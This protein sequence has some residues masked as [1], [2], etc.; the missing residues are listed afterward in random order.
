MRRPFLAVLLIL[1]GIGLA[2][3]GMAAAVNPVWTAVSAKSTGQS[4]LKLMPDKFGQFN[5]DEP[6][7]KTMLVQA[8]A[9]N[10]GGGSSALAQMSTVVQVPLPSGEL[11]ELA[12]AENAT[13]APELAA[14]FP[15]IKT[16]TA[17]ASDL[18]AVS[19]T[20]DFTE[21]GF[22][23]M[24]YTAQGTVLIDP[25]VD[26]NGARTYISYYKTDYHPAD[27]APMTC[28]V[29]GNN[30]LHADH[31]APLAVSSAADGA[32][33]SGA[34]L[35]TYRLALA[36]TG[37]YSTFHGGT[38]PLAL[39]AMV[40]SINRVNQIYERDLAVRLQLVANNNLLVY[41]NAA[42]DPYSNFDGFSMLGENQTNV[43]NVIGPANYDIGHV[44]ST[45]GGG[46]AGLGVV[47]GSGKGE[48]VTGSP[49]PTGDPFDIDYVAHEIGHQF[50]GDHSFNGTTGS[51]SGNRNASTAWE[52]GSGTTIMAYAGICGGENLQLNSDSL[53][54]AGSIQEMITFISAAP[55]GASC[56]SRTALS[57]VA[58]VA[59]AG[60]DYTIPANTPFVLTGSG[61]DANGSDTLSYTWE[62]MSLGT[63]STAGDMGDVG[64]RP[65]FRSFN[66]DAS[67][68]RTFPKLESLRN[69]TT[70]IGERLPTTT[71]QLNFRLTVRDQHGGV[72]DDDVVL[73]V[74]ADAGPF[75]VTAPNG[76]ESLSSSTT[77]TWNVANTNLAPVS[78]A[79]VNI[80]LSTDG[81]TTFPVSLLSNAPNNGSATVNF[82]VGTSNTARLKVQCA[83]NIFFDISNNNFT[84]NSV[85][86]PPTYTLTVNSAGASGVAIGAVP[87]TYAGTTNYSKTGIAA[88]TVISLSAPATSGDGSFSSWSGCDSS[89]GASCSVTMNAARTVTAIYNYVAPA[90][91]LIQNPGFES[92]ATSWTQYAFNGAT[93]IGTSGGVPAH[94]GSKFAHLGG[95][96]S[97]NDYVEQTIAIPANVL[98]AKIEFWYWILSQEANPGAANDLLKVELYSTGGTKLATLT[99][100]SNLNA[101]AGWLKSTALDVSA[102]K[103]QTVR[104][105]FSA[106][107]NATL[108]T[109]FNV[110]DVSLLTVVSNAKNLLPSMLLLLD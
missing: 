48:G 19:G 70:D 86:P 58:P 80:S 96:N 101:S 42:T 103:G 60:A 10:P 78:C 8:P 28:G 54:H 38:V 47:C 35:T 57:N 2:T 53:F 46:I 75:L 92:G 72:A 16:F 73:S 43:N 40:T 84:Y 52:P 21:Q 29:H 79:S 26:G 106:T 77:V 14:K 83:G 13:M 91:N 36:A 82:P 55:G 41:T 99:T 24:L 6:T 74:R 20:V 3:S 9:L 69:N 63:A 15:S 56:G 45:G 1:S 102:Y 93:P 5:L 98:T 81:G 100:L 4:G 105:R 22:H 85:A 62:N 50:G 33:R 49:S 90:G 37:E 39:S 30:D 23:A 89:A 108:S 34:Q 67:P 25:R 71:R 110:D 97:A 68:A 18:P 66:P 31:A 76:G 64:S 32:A 107:S 17:Y 51:C 12:V 7:M 27:K 95:Y 104:L 109:A 59:N 61:T 65:L 94:S 88:S 44:F 87:G 11:I